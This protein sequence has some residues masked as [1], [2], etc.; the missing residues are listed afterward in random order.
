[1]LKVSPSTYA[2]AGAASPGLTPESF[3]SKLVSCFQHCRVMLRLYVT[4][5]VCVGAGGG[6]VT[7]CRYQVQKGQKE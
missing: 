7:L 2:K 5:L 1:G 3:T 6:L 4:L